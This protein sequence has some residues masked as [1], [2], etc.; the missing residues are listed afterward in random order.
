MREVTLLGVYRESIFSPGKIR[1]DAAILE[2]TLTEL[3]LR[4]YKTAAAQPRE[5]EKLSD[6]PAFVLTMAQ[7]RRALDILEGWQ[8]QGTRIINSVSSIRNTYRKPLISLLSEAR[9]PIPAGKILRVHEVERKVP[10]QGSSI[11]WLKRGDVHATQ[12]EDVAKVTSGD[13]LMRA[14][15]HFRS[16]RIDEVLVQEHVSGEVIKFYGVAKGGYFRAFLA[17]NGDEVTA[18]M[19]PLSALAHRSAETVGLEIYGGDCV[20]KEEGETILVDL[21]DW[22]SFS[23]CC[24]SAAQAIAQYIT[25]VCEGGLHG[26]PTRC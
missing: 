14:L 26:L 3:S 11:Y 17:S 23:R 21:N 9:L 4:G 2:A 7:S 22:P 12:P 1:E 10:F 16:Q 25:S 8:K 19:E 15:C 6:R 20:V 24:R 5:L 18:R 13:E